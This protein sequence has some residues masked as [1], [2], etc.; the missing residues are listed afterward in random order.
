MET[1]TLSAPDLARILQQT[2]PHR[3]AGTDWKDGAA[4]LIEAADQRLHAVTTDRYTIA[5]ATADLHD[6]PET[7]TDFRAVLLDGDA[8]TLQAWA[9]SRGYDE[10]VRLTTDG[11][12][13]DATTLTSKL[14]L[15]ITTDG[16]PLPGWRDFIAKHLT[17]DGPQAQ[18]AGLTAEGLRR[19]T[20]HHDVLWIGTAGPATPVTFRGE[21]F[22]GLHMASKRPAPLL[23]LPSGDAATADMAPATL[24]LPA[25]GSHFT[26]LRTEMLKR[27]VVGE[28]AVKDARADDDGW[29]ATERI[30]AA[31]SA[32]L[33]QRLL[34]RLEQ[35]DPRLAHSFARQLREE[36]DQGDFTDVAYE[37]AYGLGLAPADW[38]EEYRGAKDA[39][40]VRT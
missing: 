40:L 19:W 11:Q 8:D 7:A 32:W 18:P 16:F 9:A 21:N 30:T 2:A 36:L 35:L 3:S 34:E 5:V 31:G 14:R 26:V 10:A 25:P 29:A 33:A 23:L 20:E 15:P 22:I 1:L 28:E 27:V 6:V 12:Q 37:V 4:T 24:P 38:T 39:Y 17:Q 13:L